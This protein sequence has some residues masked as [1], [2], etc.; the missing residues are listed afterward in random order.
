[1]PEASFLV[2]IDLSAYAQT[3]EPA[4][5]L[6]DHADICCN[7]GEEFGIEKVGFTCFNFGCARPVLKESL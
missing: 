4:Q 7:A 2:W 3:V 5:F 6:L 1:M